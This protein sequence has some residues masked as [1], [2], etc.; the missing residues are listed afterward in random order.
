MTVDPAD[1]RGWGTTFRASVGCLPLSRDESARR[2]LHAVEGDTTPGRRL[3]RCTL[4]T[5]SMMGC[6]VL[7]GAMRRRCDGHLCGNGPQKA[8]QLTGNSHDDLLGLFASGHEAP[9]TVTEPH[10]RLPTDVLE[11]FRELFQPQLQMVT[12]LGRIA[13]GPGPCHESATGMGIARFGHGT[14]APPLPGG[15]LRGNPPQKCHEGSRI[16]AARQGAE[17]GYRCNGHRELHAA[18]CLEGLDHRGESP[19][20]YLLFELLLTTLERS[21]CSLTARTYA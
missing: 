12:H 5:C 10:L 4:A 3:F 20:L 13:R 21:V 1:I 19:R 8:H 7:H 6:V 11:R 2:S 15:I 18:Q 16:L 14:L 9:G 17:C